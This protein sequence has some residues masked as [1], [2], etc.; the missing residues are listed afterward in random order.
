MRHLEKMLVV[1]GVCLLFLVQAI[2]LAENLVKNPGFEVDKNGDGLPD[3]WYCKGT[4]WYEKPK[5]EGC[6]KVT[7][8]SIVKH[9]GDKSV[10]LHGDYDRG[11]IIQKIEV[12]PGTTYKVSGWIKIEGNV[13]AN[14]NMTFFKTP[15]CSAG[16]LKKGADVGIVTGPTD[17]R[18]VEKEIT[19]PEEVRGL[20]FT[21]L[22]PDPN[23]GLVWFDDICIQKADKMIAKR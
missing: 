19:I 2:A 22:T 3:S 11:L 6:S 8:D 12:S 15:D 4:G 21:P 5:G 13:R 1:I 7:L 16:K 20:Y 10:C 14:L 23:S 18:Y 9:S 17:W